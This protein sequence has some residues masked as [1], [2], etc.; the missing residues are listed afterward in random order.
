MHATQSAVVAVTGGILASVFIAALLALLFI[1]RYRLCG[2]AAS[3][4]KKK[5]QDSDVQQDVFHVR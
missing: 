1:C 4:L 2:N 3:S 5:D